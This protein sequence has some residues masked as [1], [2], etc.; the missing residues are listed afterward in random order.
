MVQ[1]MKIIVINHI[2]HRGVQYEKC[3]IQNEEKHMN[4]ITSISGSLASFH[5]IKNTHQTGYGIKLT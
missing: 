5:D 2:N 1:Q 4:N 3:R